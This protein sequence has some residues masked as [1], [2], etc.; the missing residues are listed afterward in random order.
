MALMRHASSSLLLFLELGRR[1]LLSF[2]AVSICN[3]LGF[4]GTYPI[5]D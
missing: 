1:R 5:F 3:R 2:L 4:R